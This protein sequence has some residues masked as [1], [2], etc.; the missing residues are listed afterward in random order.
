LPRRTRPLVSVVIP[1]FNAAETL[2]E[3]A[4]SALAGI[5]QDIELIIVDDGSRDATADVAEEIAGADARVRS[6][7]R[8]NGGVSAAFNT[9]L[10][11]ATGDYVAR[12]DADDLWHPEK[13]E[14]QMHAALKRPDIAFLYTDVRYI[15]G[16]GRVIRD[17]APQDFPER[18]LCRGVCESIV[19]GNSSCLMR[20]DAVVEAGGYDETLSSWEDLLL[21]LQM[22]A[23]HPIARVSGYLVG[24]RVRPGSLSARP[25]NMLSSWRLVRER[26]KTLFPQVPAFVLDWADGRRCAEL[27]ESF[28]WAGSWRTSASLLL[29]AVR[30][31]PARTWR[32]LAYRTA[33]HVRNR[34]SRTKTATTKHRFSGCDPGQSVGMSDFDVSAEGRRL[35]AF[36]ERRAEFLRVLDERLS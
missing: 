22:S 8:E 29:E 36:D 19:G 23:R 24:Y 32:F 3:S 34:F 35:R 26:I 9:G 30:N 33:R 15:D 10:M 13:L 18:S 28:A 25:D 20:R 11:D 16:D 27:A 7:R 17:V 4:L 6:L 21:Q 14:R 12:L 2:R 31:D 5:Y 1:A